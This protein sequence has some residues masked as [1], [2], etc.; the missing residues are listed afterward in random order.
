MGS[1]TARLFHDHLLVKEPRTAQPT[2]WHQDQP[3]YNVSGEPPSCQGL[4]GVSIATAACCSCRATLKCRGMR[5]QVLK[6][7]LSGSRST[8]CRPRPR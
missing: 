4:K 2:P 6:T 7:Y 1:E 3:Y 5:A 8:Q